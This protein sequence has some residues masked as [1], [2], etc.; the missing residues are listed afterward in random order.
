[1]G[2]FQVVPL[3][4]SVLAKL[5][6]TSLL[7]AREANLILETLGRPDRVRGRLSIAPQDTVSTVL[8]VLGY[9]AAFWASAHL[10]K[11]RRRRR[12]I[13]GAIFLGALLQLGIGVVEH[14]ASARLKGSFVN[15]NHLAGHLEI[16]MALAFA[17]VWITLSRWSRRSPR[18]VSTVERRLPPV[19]LSILLWSTLAAGIGLTR[20]RGG[21]IAA[22]STAVI[23]FT[24][25]V[26][27]RRSHAKPK[28]F[29]PALLAFGAAGIF[30]FTAIGD[31]P[32]LRFREVEGQDLTASTRLVIFRASFDAFRQFP[33]LGSGLGSFRE[34]FRRTQPE[35]FVG[36][37]EQAHNEYLQLLVTGGVVGLGLGIGALFVGTRVLLSLSNRQRHREERAVSLAGFG[38]LLTL[39]I[40]G[41]GEF[42][43]SLP[44]IPATLSVALGLAYAAA[45]FEG[46][47]PSGAFGPRRAP[48]TE[49]V[50]PA[51]VRT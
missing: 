26:T 18:L 48:S 28:A 40:H 7:I 24:L 37:V 6:P 2:L 45:R 29:L 3:P 42:N 16:S 36:L 46:S 33:V 27:R 44:A 30:V 22:V 50:G 39:L 49:N 34:A 41:L 25:A 1:M 8:L 38:A 31:I 4:D 10:L 35:T 13:L 5:S 20:S 32:L 11:T 14:S 23:L 15:P 43:F 12:L 9:V 47:E 17:P 19:A 21:L 51:S